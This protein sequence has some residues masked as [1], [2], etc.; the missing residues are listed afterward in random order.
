VI[1]V[2]ES[3]YTPSANR[4]DL[5]VYSQSQPNAQEW[6]APQISATLQEMIPCQTVARGEPAPKDQVIYPIASTTSGGCPV[7]CSP[8]QTVPVLSIPPIASPSWTSE[9]SSASTRT[10]RTTGGPPSSLD[11]I[12]VIISRREELD[13]SLLDLKNPNE[14][15]PVSPSAI[16]DVTVKREEPKLLSPDDVD[17]LIGFNSFIDQLAIGPSGHSDH[18]AFHEVDSSVVRSFRL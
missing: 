12:N 17:E 3:C 2:I 4:N 8:K 11:D 15:F 16:S 13:W 1:E 14:D 5:K 6:R 10:N 9:C 7:Y 18:P